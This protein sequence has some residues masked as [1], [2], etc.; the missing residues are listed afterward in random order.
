MSRVNVLTAGSSVSMCK[1]GMAWLSDC[2]DLVAAL[3]R[4][5][6]ILKRS[7][8]DA[9]QTAV[10]GK[11]TAGPSV[12]LAVNKSDSPTSTPLSMSPF[13]SLSNA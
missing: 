2:H 13:P 9:S 3:N 10:D 1:G 12:E 6:N 7:C 11:P 8:S 5:R 4:R